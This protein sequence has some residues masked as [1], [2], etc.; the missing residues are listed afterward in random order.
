MTNSKK[1]MKSTPSVVLRI[2]LLLSLHVLLSFGAEKPWTLDAIMALKSVSDPQISPDGSKVAYVVREAN[3]QRKAYDSKI[4]IV[5][6]SGGKARS[7]NSPHFSDSRPRWSRAGDRLAFLS[8]RDKTAQ[9]YVVDTPDGTPRK[10]TSSPTGVIDFKWSPDGSQVGYLAVDA[11][12]SEERKR[13][14]EGD[15]PIVANQGYRYS[16]LYR[17]PVQG[18]TAQRV[19]TANRH[20]TSFDWAPDGLRVVY[21]AQRTPR[22][23]DTFH[24]DLYELDLPAQRETPLVV[25]EGRDADPCYSR[26]G[27]W[28][29]F[30]SQAGKINYF[31]ERHVGIIPSGGGEIRYLTRKLPADVF[32][33]G[34][35]FWWGQDALIFGAGAGTQDHLYSVSVKDGTSSRLIAAL[36]GPS[37][38]SVSLDGRRIA[39]L[40]S[41]A[42]TSP[43]VHLAAQ[44]GL[45]WT[46][47]PL[48]AVNSEVSSL[49]KVT[50]RTLRWKSRDGL[51]VEG[52]LRLPFTYREGT[53]VPLLV[54]LHGGPTGVALEGFPISRTYP[55]QLFLQEGFAVLAPNFRGS[56]NYGGKFRLANIESQ[57]FGDFDDVMTGIDLLVGQGIADPDRLGVMG[58]SY[59]G[60][61][62]AWILGHSDRFKAVS[63]GAPGVDWISWYGISDGPREVLWT[64]FGGKPWDRWE[65]YNRHSPR[66]SL[67]NAKT[68]SLLLH[69][70]EDIDDVSEIFEALTDLNVLAE[71]VTYPREGHGIGEPAHQRDL[72]RR[73]LEWFK[74]WVLQNGE[75]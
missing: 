4:W 52:V 13:I 73:N 23:R 64:Y 41:S 22:N 39:F 29:A 10:L 27:R 21:A 66:Y 45:Q 58:W 43:Q 61:L 60:F 56:S 59:G 62:S 18:G 16:G 54:E 35:E 38:F 63:V 12:T 67:R 28:I 36:A 37:S 50:A 2:G 24:V 69:G 15:D 3:F 75:R 20:V 7:L 14:D 11:R 48:T 74:R 19:T 44:T 25:Q 17:V 55:I 1:M 65:T 8:R 51:E 47:T 53:R 6:A 71:F 33:G 34:N 26:D 31:E 5:S 32:R 46:E 40:K 70:E 30:H 68:P 57:G 42:S 9:V 72:L 49:P